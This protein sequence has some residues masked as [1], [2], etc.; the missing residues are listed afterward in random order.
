MRSLVLIAFGLILATPASAQ[1][2]GFRNANPVGDQHRFETERLRLQSDQRTIEARQQALNARLTQLELQSRRQ[3]TTI[4]S[5][6]AVTALSLEQARAAREAATARRQA[7][8]EDVTRIDDW[9]D[10][11]RN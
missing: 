3:S 6:P 5:D 1:V 8:V 2:A 10:Q 4:S 7:I 9:L 11:P